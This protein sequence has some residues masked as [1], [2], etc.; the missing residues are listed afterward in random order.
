MDIKGKKITVIGIGESGRSAAIFLK[1]KGAAVFLTDS[2]ASEEIEK[3]AAQLRNSGI[4]VETGKHTKGFVEGSSF[5]VVSPGVPEKALPVQWARQLNIEIIGEI[6]LGYRFCSGRIIAITGTNGKSTTCTLLE[7]ILKDAKKDALLCGNIGEAFIGKIDKVSRDTIV[8]LEISSFQLEGITSF[9]PYISVILN[10]SQN[11]LDRHKDLE[12]YFAAKQRIYA[13]QTKEDYAV[14]NYDDENLKA[15]L[16]LIKNTNTLSFSRKILVKG[17]YA[18]VNKM[19]LNVKDLQEIAKIKDLKLKQPHN[20]ENFL[21]ASICASLCGVPAAS[22]NKTL[23]TFQG[24]TYRIQLVAS[25]NGV[26]YFDDSKATTVESAKAALRSMRGKVI[27]IAGGRDKGSDFTQAGEEI[28]R[29][30]KRLILI[31]E[32]KRQM[33]EELSGFA[34]TTEAS[35]M[36]EAVKIAA[37]SASSGDSVLLSPM[38]ASFDMFKDYKHRGDVF[39]QAVI[40]LKK[41]P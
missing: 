22:I 29:K 5:V 21:A 37:E 6:E 31:G 18:N 3:S 39:K 28:K 40:N 41:T 14:L 2:G 19:F 25:I 10:I 15:L 16:P 30:V 38:C 13:F 23:K 12:E 32:A 4:E 27:L 11:H 33:L 20:I 17:A 9:K 35:D 36:D 1:K 7:Q 24:L 26:D 34:D 8:V